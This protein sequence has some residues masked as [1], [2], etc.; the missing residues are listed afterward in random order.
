MY[1][2]FGTF[3]KISS[4]CTKEG[5]SGTDLCRALLSCFNPDKAERITGQRSSA[6]MN[7][8]E[9]INPEFISVAITI[10][11]YELMNRIQKVVIP[12]INTNEYKRLVKALQTAVSES[13]IENDVCFN[14]QP[15][16][17]FVKQDTVSLVPF[18][19]YLLSFVIQNTKNGNGKTD[20][21]KINT[22][23]IESINTNNTSVITPDF[24]GTD[25]SVDLTICNEDFHAVFTEISS[26][27]LTSLKTPNVIKCY[28]LD[29]EESG[30]SFAELNRFL[31]QNVGKYIYDRIGYE[32]LTENPKD[33]PTIAAKALK[34][35]RK[36]HTENNNEI[37]EMLVFSFLEGALKAPKIMS[38][39]EIEQEE[40]TERKIAH[41]SSG[42]HLLTYQSDGK[43]KHQFVF[44]CYGIEGNIYSGIDEAVKRLGII[45]KKN[46]IIDSHKLLSSSFFNKC[47]DDETSEFLKSLVAPLRPRQEPRYENG[48][49]VFVGYSHNY[50]GTE[51]GELYQKRIL[52]KVG[53]DILEALPYIEKKVMEEG[54]NLNSVYFYFLPFNDAVKD[55]SDIQ[56][57]LVE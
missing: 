1:F 15:C 3:L 37:G 36:H 49:G 8:D 19:S 4:L 27:Q 43:T 57:E 25:V 47:F 12:L 9:N 16:S 23:W 6:L 53:N 45:S 50:K 40:N 22:K 33:Y 18:L 35:L 39:Y 52:D 55:T 42:I 26:Q 24:A 34:L 54:L 44:S 41:Y 51:T 5:I 29:F 48:F 10:N 20:I 56:K 14:G 17:L 28:S 30:F 32:G 21:E 38:R 31:L 2:C 7:C 46:N 13:Q 11:E